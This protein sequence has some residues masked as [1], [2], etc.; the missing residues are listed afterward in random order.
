L[1]WQFF[2][3]FQNE[4]VAS[5]AIIVKQ[6]RDVSELTT[7]IFETEDVIDISRKEGITESKLIYI[8]HGSV[9]VGIDLGEF[10]D[11]DVQVEG[12]KVTVS[13]PVL[14]VLDTKLDVNQSRLYDYNKGFLS[15][16]PDLVKLQE[17]AL[18]E[19]IR[20]IEQA[21][22]KEWLMKT[23]NERVQQTA[24]SFL[25]QLLNNKGYTVSVKI[26]IPS[27]DTCPKNT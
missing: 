9:R 15:L 8:A 17:S 11:S 25:N 16:G 3:S 18:R 21:S 4:T 10:Q 20:K 2:F 14:K 1:F 26:Q 5:R 22:C 24:Q 6:V 7:A 23:A 19:S 12:K 13:L 27:D